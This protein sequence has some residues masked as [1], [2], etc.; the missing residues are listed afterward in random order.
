M[1]QREVMTVEKKKKTGK[2]EDQK[3]RWPKKL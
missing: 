2:G 3:W 1:P